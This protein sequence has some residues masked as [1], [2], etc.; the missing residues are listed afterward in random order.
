VP[1]PAASDRSVRIRRA[2]PADLA[3]LVDL[4]NRVFTAD[5]MSARQW[6]HHLH[7]ETA[8][9]LVA[10]RTGGIVGAAAV[11]FHSAH[12]IAR[13]YSIAVAPEA[14]GEGLGEAL[15]DAAEQ[16]ARRRRSRSMRLEVRSDNGPAQRLYER[17]GYARFGVRARYYADGRDALRYEK[18][19]VRG[20]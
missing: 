8:G 11:F 6:R 15:L 18:A 19:F 2:R 12:D 14:R 1:R 9:V 16:L 13:L 5:R 20:S 3:A 7:S 4:E 10:E 17:R